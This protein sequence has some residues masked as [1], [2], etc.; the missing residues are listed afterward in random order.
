MGGISFKKTIQS[1]V[2]SAVSQMTDLL[3]EEGFG[4]LTRINFHEKIQE[5]LGKDLPPTVILGACHPK[6]AYDAYLMNSDVTAL[7]PCNVVV[8]AIGNDEVSVEVTRPS[9]LLEVLK[10][11]TLSFLSQDSD[12]KLQKIVESLK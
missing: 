5:K 7:L 6:L 3:K 8:R 11:S 1:T 12:I 9:R 10:D 4:I 2:E